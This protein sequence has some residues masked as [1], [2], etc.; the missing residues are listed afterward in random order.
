MMPRLF[1]RRSANML[2]CG[3]SS[4]AIVTRASDSALPKANLDG[5][6]AHLVELAP[7]S[8]VHMQQNVDWTVCQH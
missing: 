2:L 1:M 3:D 7:I 4:G 5:C 8:T 6:I